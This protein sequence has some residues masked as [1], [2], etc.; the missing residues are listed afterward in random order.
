M[1][2]A[3]FAVLA[4]A[5]SVSGCGALQNFGNAVVGKPTATTATTVAAAENA[6]TTA[7][8][9]ETVWLKSGKATKAQAATAKELRTTVYSAVVAAR[10]A[11][12]N[13]DNPGV[14]VALNMFNTA[15]PQFTAYLS[16]N[17]GGS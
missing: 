9:L 7:A 16:A 15:L 5:G 11:V 10:T 1:A 4:L 2:L 8:N 13:G 3:G 14:A 6:F 17:G 12:A